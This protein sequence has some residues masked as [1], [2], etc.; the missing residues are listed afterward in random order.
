LKFLYLGEQEKEANIRFRNSAQHKIDY[1]SS[2]RIQ[3]WPSVKKA[4]AV[5]SLSKQTATAAK[6]ASSKPGI[7]AVRFRG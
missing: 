5:A 1:F 7:V 4:T 3:K 2:P 6:P